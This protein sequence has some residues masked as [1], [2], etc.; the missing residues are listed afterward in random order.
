MG[1]WPKKPNREPAPEFEYFMLCQGCET[2]LVRIYLSA[3]VA[4]EH[5]YVVC[6]ACRYVDSLAAS[7]KD[8]YLNMLEYD[9]KHE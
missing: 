3:T 1:L 6:P 9:L 5:V 2:E 4:L 7:T 8:F